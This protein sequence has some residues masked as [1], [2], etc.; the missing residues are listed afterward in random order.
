MRAHFPIPPLFALTLTLTLTAHTLH[1]DL[2]D[3]IGYRHLANSL[4]TNTPDGTG[5]RVSQIEAST[6]TINLVYAPVTGAGTINGSG[7]YTGKTLVLESD[8]STLSN[9][10]VNVADS[11]YG[12]NTNPASAFSSIAPGITDIHNY[13]AGHDNTTSGFFDLLL[14]GAAPFVEASRVQSHAYV[15][16]TSDSGGTTENDVLRRLD[17]GINRDGY[18]AV[19][20]MDNGSSSN[21]PFLLGSGYNSLSVGLSNGN[22]SH[23]PIPAGL[24]GQGRI[25][26][27]IVT[28]HTTTSWATGAIASAGAFHYQTLLEDFAVPPADE[29]ML[30]RAVMLA[31]ATKEESFN[32]DRT[33]SRPLDDQFGLGQLDV[34]HNHHILTGGEQNPGPITPYGWNLENITATQTHSYTFVIPEFR[35]ADCTSLIVTWNRRIRANDN[36]FPLAD[37]NLTLKDAGGTTLDQSIGTLYNYEHIFAKN[38][39][40]GTYTAEI[41]SDRTETYAL[42]WRITHGSGPLTQTSVSSTN[43]TTLAFSNL[44]PLATYHVE[45][46]P[47]LGSWNAEPTS[48]FNPSSSTAAWIDPVSIGTGNKFYRLVW[49]IPAA[50]P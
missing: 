44:D 14:N 15:S 36:P 21:V 42:A 32:W 35:F 40:A 49:D 38:L 39:P 4:G 45:S 26:P 31:G 11:F 10:A 24:D 33:Q 37:I 28:V 23:G 46:S 16:R 30:I 22:H 12:N 20:G 6:S 18:L 25:K 13:V 34:Y 41:T 19:V 47:T 17:R 5:V 27:E 1:A 43:Q 2:H 9:H 50:P 8:P 48:T 3:D 29:S 7:N